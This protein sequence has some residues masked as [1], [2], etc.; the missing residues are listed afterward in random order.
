[1][2]GGKGPE[3]EESREPEESREETEHPE[4]IRARPTAN[5]SRVRMPAEGPSRKK[6][7]GDPEETGPPPGEEG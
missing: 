4:P 7:E 3:R 6:D 2:S 1:M 5:P